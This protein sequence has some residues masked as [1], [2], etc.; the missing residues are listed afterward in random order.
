MSARADILVIDD[1]P[2]IRDAVGDV[3]REQGHHVDRVDRGQ[4]A[5]ERIVRQRPVDLAIVDCRLPDISGLELLRSIKARSPETEVILITGHASLDGALEAMAGDASSYLVK[6]VGTAQLLS[7]VDRALTR[8][9]LLR[10]LRDSEER[11]RLVAEAM[12]EALLLLDLEGGLVLLNG[13]GEQLTGYRA[14]ELVGRSVFSVLDEAGAARA[15]ERLGGREVAPEFECVMVRK[16][17]RR[18]PVEMVCT[19]IAR[20]GH[21]AGHLVVARD[22]TERKQAQAALD[23]IKGTQHEL[24]ESERLRAVGSLTEG[25][26]D[27]VRQV[28]QKILGQVQ[29]VLP[30]LEGTDGHGKLAGIKATVMEAADVLKQLQV[31]SEVRTIS[32]APPLDLNDVARAAIEAVRGLRPVGE[33]AVP[34]IEIELTPGPLPDVT[35]EASV[36]IE[37]VTA[38]LVNAI[39]V[40]PGGGTIK[41]RTWASD[42][43]VYCEVKDPGVGMS[44]A[45]RERVLE[46]FFTTKAGEHK[47]LGLSV[48]HG[49]LRRHGGDI[50]IASVEGEGTVVTLRLPAWPA[51]GA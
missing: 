38:V 36:L 51:A 40:L 10:A 3:L 27:Y 45:T 18:V 15:R 13:H 24:V 6:P 20:D 19:S 16:D 50:Q 35:G 17:G 47:G 25:V 28:L 1:D 32:E 11:Y 5:L 44:S 34:R 48:A 22:I 21:V 42:R 7:T 23:D 46:P 2:A 43:H 12:T 49:L 31:A 8:Q 14:D 33:G 26:T 37:V 30:Q 4:A 41:V 39:E 9:A 29:V